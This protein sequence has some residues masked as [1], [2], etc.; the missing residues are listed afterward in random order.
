[1]HDRFTTHLI[2]QRTAHCGLILFLSFSPCTANANSNGLPLNNS[3]TTLVPFRWHSHL[4]LIVL[5]WSSHKHPVRGLERK[6]KKNMFVRTGF[7]YPR[8]SASF[9]PLVRVFIC[10]FYDLY[11]CSRN[12]ATGSEIKCKVYSRFSHRS[13]PASCFFCFYF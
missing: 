2:T 7:P 5:Q 3:K 12:E 9:R 8:R 13:Y 1:M 11:N 6:K 4:H 10:L